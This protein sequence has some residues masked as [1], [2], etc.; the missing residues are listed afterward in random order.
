[1]TEQSGIRAG[2][3]GFDVQV[4]GDTTLTGGAITSTQQAIDTARNRFETGGELTLTDIENKAEYEAKGGS[5]NLGA[6]VSTDGKLK[7]QGTSAGFGSDSDAAQS[8]TLA[9]ISDMAGN[10]EA[11]T[12]D[13]ETGIKPIF[14]A[15]K[16]QKEIDAQVQITQLFGQQASKA[17]G[18]YAKAK[19]QEAEQQQIEGLIKKQQANRAREEGL[20]AQADAL[21]AEA[22][23]ALGVAADLRQQWGEHGSAR[24]ALHT[25]TGALTGGAGGAA[26][27]LASSASAP[28]IAD[29]A[30]EMGLPDELTN[31]LVQGAATAIGAGLGGTAGG[32][33]ALNEVSNN[34]L[35]SVQ[36]LQRDQDLAECSTLACAA[37]VRLKYLGI[38]RMQDAGLLVGIGGG[39]GYQAVEQAA[40]IIDLVKNLP[41]T[42]EALTA[43]VSDPEFRAQVGNALANEYQQRIDMQVRAYNDGGWDGSVTAGVEA[44]R[45]A[46]DIAS[47]GAT[48]L[49]V[50]KL[51]VVAGKAGANLATEA[52]VAAATKIPGKF[53]INSFKSADDLNALMKAHE[54]APAWKSGTQVAETTLPAGTRVQMVVDETTY[55]NYLRSNKTEIQ[56]G[57]WA[58]LDNVP[59]QAYVRNQ[60][61][62]TPDMKS[63]VGYVVELEV[64]RPIPAQIGVVGPQ[65]GSSGGG[66]QLHFILDRNARNSAFKVVRER[67]L[68]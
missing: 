21:Q 57:G 68:K 10:K 12:G 26:G 38:S 62:I 23:T 49:G 18:D 28:Y 51:A 3:G 37:G 58:T 64:T 65:G 42:L 59:S 30:K 2:D 52:I 13:A 27:A 56:L 45:L 20:F 15:E 48:A 1:M 9:A 24:L 6:G 35:T 55:L 31:I 16:V 66:N 40:A 36:E 5:V 46:V 33:A 39:M 22:D 14:D 43:I 63:N 29:A 34:Y 53:G 67:V 44:G 11:R 17:I 41:E 47:A 19:L 60:L 50:G 32:A 54:W 25:L 7:P 4:G 61:A 8:M